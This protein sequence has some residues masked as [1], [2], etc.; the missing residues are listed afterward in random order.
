VGPGEHRLLMP[1]RSIRP[2][3][4]Q[5]TPMFGVPPVY[6]TAMDLLCIDLR[7]KIVT[8]KRRDPTNKALFSGQGRC[9]GGF[10]EGR[11]EV[12]RTRCDEH[13]MPR[14]DARPHGPHTQQE[15]INR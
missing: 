4:N 7:D 10:D 6:E 3:E 13:R 9:A 8:N 11:K 1:R 5:G 14:F 15:C 12:R 2:G